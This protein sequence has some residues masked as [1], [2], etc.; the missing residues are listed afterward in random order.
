[1]FL[2]VHFCALCNGSA[3]PWYV[4]L[5]MS[6]KTQIANPWSAHTFFHGSI[7]IHGA[8]R[9]QPTQ[10]KI[11]YLEE[12]VERSSGFTSYLLPLFDQATI[13]SRCNNLHGG[14]ETCWYFLLDGS[15]TFAVSTF[16][17]AGKEICSLLTPT[18]GCQKRSMSCRQA[19]SSVR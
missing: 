15:Y 19:A 11:L 5:H 9:G 17:V 12:E 6:S 16:W 18:F 1:M 7:N 4:K 13:K 2:L 14:V 10:W 3:L 8:A